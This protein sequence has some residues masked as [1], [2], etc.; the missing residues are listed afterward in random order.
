[1]PR[2]AACWRRYES[3][4]YLPARAAL[5]LCV[6][7]VD[8][9]AHDDNINIEYEMDTRH[10]GARRACRLFDMPHAEESVAQEAAARN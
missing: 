2:A 7:R 9:T 6:G 4:V 5:L 3:D 8:T 1:M 10:H